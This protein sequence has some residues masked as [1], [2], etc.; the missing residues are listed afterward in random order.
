MPSTTLTALGLFFDLIGAVLLA[1]AII[2]RAYR[3]NRI[4]KNLRTEGVDQ[5]PFS[6]NAYLRDIEKQADRL[7]SPEKELEKY[8]RE[9]APIALAILFLII[10]YMLQIVA[11]FV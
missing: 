11:L 2:S 10:G 1:P 7:D 6:V 4:Y 9:F 3:V 8:V 5:T